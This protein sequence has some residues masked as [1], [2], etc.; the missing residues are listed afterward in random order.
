MFT[1]LCCKENV[2][3]ELSGNKSRLGKKCFDELLNDSSRSLE[4]ILKRLPYSFK[5]RSACDVGAGYGTLA[6]NLAL[7]GIKTTAVE[8]T[9]KERRVIQ[10]LLGENPKARKYLKIVNGQAEKL[11][12]RNNS[13]DLCMLSQVLEHVENPDMAMGE[14]SRILRPG[15]YLHLGSPNYIFPMEQHYRLGY[16]PLMPKKMLYSWIKFYFKYVK[17]ERFKGGELL[18]TRKF[19]NSLNYTTDKM[20]RSLCGRYGLRVIWSLSDQEKDLLGQVRNHFR[21][22]P[23]FFQV[24]LIIISLPKKIARVLFAYLGILPMKLEYLMRKV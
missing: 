19:V 6:I 2:L 20:I 18:E 3:P 5:I 11:P 23:S 12:F 4:F 1:N 24:F 13:F 14:V 10:K 17:G 9:D 7:K 21:Q 16:F 22:N 15:G 8:P